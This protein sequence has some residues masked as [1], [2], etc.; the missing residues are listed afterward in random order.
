MVT[1]CLTYKGEKSL[2]ILKLVVGR[3]EG[4]GMGSRVDFLP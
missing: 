4:Q 2:S 3:G 1:Y